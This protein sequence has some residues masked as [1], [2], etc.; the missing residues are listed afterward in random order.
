MV[1]LDNLV[2]FKYN[3][4]MKIALF[5]DSFFPG[6]GGT[7][8]AVYHI[9]L[10]LSKGDEVMVVAPNYHRIDE[11]TYPFK[12]VRFKSLGFS[13]ND[14]W[15]MP[16]L[17][18]KAKK[19]IA[20]FAPDI[21]HCHTVGTT[22]A[23]ANKYAKKHGVPL[24]YTV[25]TKFRYCYKKAL[26]IGLFAEILL[27]FVMRRPKK[28]DHLCSVCNSMKSELKSYGL[29]NPVTVVRNGCNFKKETPKPKD[30]TLGKINLIFV[31]LMV[32][33]KRVP[34]ILETAKR[35][36]E[37]GVEVSLKLVGAGAD[38]EKYKR[39][40]KKLG[41]EKEAIFMGRITNPEI[42]KQEYQKSDLLI[43]PSVFDNA[44]LT[45]LEAGSLGVPS[46]VVKDSGASEALTDG[47]TGFT[48]DDNIDA[49]VDRIYELAFD[50]E[51]LEK[52]S[53]NTGDIFNDWE[54]SSKEYYQIY[55]DLIEKKNTL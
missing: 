15:A 1:K 25:H 19:E 8:K 31:G 50:K 11:R 26:K 17:S 20:E 36:K 4:S 54:T 42:L 3:L 22:V 49:F 53:Q 37:K 52:V 14:F 55:Q 21:I 12:V 27:K 41:I 47:V 40:V 23:Y 28:A 30:K 45:V 33:F 32:D 24:V 44:P 13:Q 34:F 51:L 35:L 39:Q 29:G 6:I 16:F 5:T 48:C 7:E 18:K 10:A 9:A 2:W 43:F 38:L 46:V